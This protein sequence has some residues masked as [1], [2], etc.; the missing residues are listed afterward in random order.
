MGL[1][2]HF[3]QTLAKALD[4]IFGKSRTIDQAESELSAAYFQRR[5][6]RWI[7]RDDV[8]RVAS[9]KDLVVVGRWHNVATPTLNCFDCDSFWGG[10]LKR[11]GRL[12]LFQH[13]NFIR[14]QLQLSV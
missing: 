2:L 7:G 9:Q 14:Q 1:V 6:T 13:V 4:F 10:H 12:R 5:N 3:I 8:E 11:R